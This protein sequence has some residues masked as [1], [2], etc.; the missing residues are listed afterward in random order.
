MIL[1]FGTSFPSLFIDIILDATINNRNNSH[2]FN[3]KLY[4]KHFYTVFY[5]KHLRGSDTSDTHDQSLYTSVQGNSVQSGQL[6]TSKK[7]IQT[8][9]FS[10]DGITS[11]NQDK[12][13]ILSTVQNR[14]DENTKM[15]IDLVSLS[16]LR[17]NEMKS[18]CQK[19]LSQSLV[20]HLNKRY[21]TLHP[22]VS[23]KDYHDMLPKP[24]YFPRDLFVLDLFDSNPFLLRL[25]DFISN[26]YPSLFCLHLCDMRTLL[27]GVIGEW[28]MLGNSQHFKDHFFLEYFSNSGGKF[29]YPM[30]KQL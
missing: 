26:H 6:K 25:F 5:E 9:Q 14:I 1:V 29:L 12:A 13:K 23:D 18:T 17:N 4:T 8:A 30:M 28:H 7:C 22:V 20:F 16:C 27:A 24:T 11:V 10:S 3:L 15:M 19:Y 21:S 2:L